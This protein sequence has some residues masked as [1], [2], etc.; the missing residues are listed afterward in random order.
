M[1]GKR[2]IHIY[3]HICTCTWTHTAILRKPGVCRV[4][5]MCVLCWSGS[6][7][8]GLFN[9]PCLPRK[10]EKCCGCSRAEQAGRL[11]I[12]AD[13]IYTWLNII[14]WLK[15]L[16]L[17]YFLQVQTFIE[18]RY[19]HYWYMCPKMM[20]SNVII[21]VW[22][23]WHFAIKNDSFIHELSKYL[24]IILIVAEL[25]KVHT[26]RYEYWYLCKN[27]WSK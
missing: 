22:V 23:H 12:E 14:Q 17:L 21:R 13:Y 16:S 15:L 7:H 10:K 6:K 9:V 20:F 19:F 27:D 24:L 2:Y 3:I 18:G 11:D 5:E 26:F 8:T 4:W 1:S 25:A